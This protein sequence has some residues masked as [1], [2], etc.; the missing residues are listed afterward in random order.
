MKKILY[1]VFLLAIAAGCTKNED[2]TGNDGDGLVPITISS[3]VDVTVKAP[4]TE[5]TPTITAGIA[6][7]E[8]S[9]TEGPDYTEACKWNTAI[10]FPP[11]TTAQAVTW[12]AQQYY[13]PTAEISTYM[14]AWYPA[15]TVVAETNKVTFTNNDGSVDA[16]WA[17]PQHGNKT[18][19][20]VTLPFKHMTAQ[21]NFE[22]KGADGLENGTKL[23][24]ITVKSVQLPNGFDLTKDDAEA[25]TYATAADLAVPNIASEGQVID[26]TT[27]KSAGDAVMVKPQAELYIDVVT[28]SSGDKENEFLNRKVQIKNDGTEGELLA[29][30]AYTISLTFSQ[31]EIQLKASVEE[32]KETGSGTA[33]ID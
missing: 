12:T 11:Q 23:K 27:F 33:T 26:N 7:W 14:K 16:L 6:G 22:I 10:T 1:S 24:S 4:V 5:G 31:E 25:V 13:N 2:L 17:T 30:T 9:E 19:N 20:E 18:G 8:T 21:L 32:W 29:G 15:G 28:V 3:G